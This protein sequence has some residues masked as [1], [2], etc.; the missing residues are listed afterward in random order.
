MEGNK[1]ETSNIEK[2]LDGAITKKDL[3]VILAG[4]GLVYKYKDL[5]DRDKAVK[6]VASF[7][8]DVMTEVGK[9]D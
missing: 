6:I 4:A 8:K 3:A 1:M 9:D 5:F 7:I 2:M